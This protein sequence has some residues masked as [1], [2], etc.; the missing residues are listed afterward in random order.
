MTNLP[1]PF[2]PLVS[3]GEGLDRYPSGTAALATR[4]AAA[5]T[6]APVATQQGA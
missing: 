5:K 1:A 6:G 2:A 4:M 3:G